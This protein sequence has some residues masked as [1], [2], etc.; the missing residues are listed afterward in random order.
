MFGLH[1]LGRLIGIKTTV[2]N[3]EHVP[4][5]IIDNAEINVDV[6]TGTIATAARQDTQSGHLVTINTSLDAIEAAQAAQATAAKQDTAAAVLTTMNTSLDNI[7][8]DADAI[9]TASGAVADAEASG[10]GSI[11]AI[12]KRIR[13]LLGLNPQTTLASLGVQAL[14]IS[15]ASVALTV[16]GGAKHAIIS[17]VG[18]AGDN[19]RFRFDGTAAVATVGQKILVGDYLDLTDPFGDFSTLLAGLRLIRDTAATADVVAHVEYFS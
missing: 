6:D 16:A 2:V 4:H 3:G 11:I 5:V 10:N 7:E 14:T 9:A 17:F 8:A 12:L 13:T 15:T 18:T 1:S 19:V